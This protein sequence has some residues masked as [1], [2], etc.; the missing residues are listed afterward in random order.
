M[1][2]SSG[3]GFLKKY[4][5][6]RYRNIPIIFVKSRNDLL[7]REWNAAAAGKTCDLLEKEA[8]HFSETLVRIF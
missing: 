6:Q 4:Y 3:R 5:L 8:A 2:T 1:W 7:G